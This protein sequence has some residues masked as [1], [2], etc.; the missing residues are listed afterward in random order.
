[1]SQNWKEDFTATFFKDIEWEQGFKDP[2]LAVGQNCWPRTAQ[3][4][5]P[6]LGTGHPRIWWTKEGR[7]TQTRKIIVRILKSLK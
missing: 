4:R 3:D 7:I 6:A 5:T 1:M 2:H